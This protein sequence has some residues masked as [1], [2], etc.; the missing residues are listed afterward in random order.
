MNN[1]SNTMVVA[2]AMDVLG[3]VFLANITTTEVLNWVYTSL[4]IASIALGIIL[5]LVSVFK[6]KKVTE[7]ELQELKE[8]VDKAK[9]KLEEETKKEDK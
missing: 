2:D 7:K 1:A 5:K 3:Y 4:L 8:E 6:D 9:K